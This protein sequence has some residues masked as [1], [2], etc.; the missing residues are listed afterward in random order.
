VKQR[1]ICD[2]LQTT[3]LQ[4]WNCTE[5][6]VLHPHLRYLDP[7]CLKAG[8]QETATNMQHFPTNSSASVSHTIIEFC[9]NQ[10][11]SVCSCCRLS[12]H[13]RSVR[14]SRNQ[15]PLYPATVCTDSSKK[16]QGREAP[17]RHNTEIVTGTMG[18]EAWAHPKGRG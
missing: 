10:T 6:C 17:E 12:V 3:A 8:T 13:W 9:H 1:G 15:G 7:S 2:I 18:H 14:V 16:Q 5:M 4:G 11:R